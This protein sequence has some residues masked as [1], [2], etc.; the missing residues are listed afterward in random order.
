MKKYI[1]KRIWQMFVVLFLVSV[2]CFS[3]VRFIPGDPIKAIFG[4]VQY[5]EEE[6]QEL[7]S[8][9]GLDKPYVEQYFIWIVNFCQ[10]DFGVSYTFN[11]PVRDLIIQRAPITL[12]LTTISLL[13]SIAL[14]ICA[15]VFTA[16]KRGKP[17]D[18]II[19]L[20]ANTTHCVPNFWLALLLVFLFSV[21]LGWLPSY[22]FAWPSEGILISFKT[23]LLP[24]ICFSL[25]PIAGITRQTRSCMLEV[26]R[27]DYMRTAK[28]KG[29]KRNTVIFQH[30]LRNA[31]I[32]LIT[33]M[34]MYVSTL[35]GG[36]AIIEQVFSIPG[37]GSLLMTSV[38]ARDFPVIQA[39]VLLMATFSIVINLIVDILYGYIDPRIRLS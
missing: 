15:G 22:G 36:S 7:R 38:S 14:G 39:C 19:T 27:Q 2:F 18:T 26:I 34:G 31:L 20:L 13:I 21:S 35:L 5:T 30:G 33:F 1:I 16:V 4:E 3:L 12:Y 28:A 37:M 23:C 9:L 10:G 25:G 8:E 11:R 6:Y 29:L 17:S 24:I 32:P